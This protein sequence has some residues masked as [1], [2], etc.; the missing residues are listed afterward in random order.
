MK[1]PRRAGAS[2]GDAEAIELL[3]DLERQTP[4]EIRRQRS[5][6]RIEIKAGVAIRSGDSGRSLEP[7]VQ[8]VTGDLSAQGCRVLS[9]VPVGVGDVFRLEFDRGA[10]DLPLI[11]AR[12]LRCRLIRED[13]FELGFEFFTPIR[14]ADVLNDGALAADAAGVQ[15]ATSLI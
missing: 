11:F 9:P 8:A 4:E 7:A 14:V 15:R 5:S 10:V 13:A 3:R 12:C 1:D 6:D 2:G